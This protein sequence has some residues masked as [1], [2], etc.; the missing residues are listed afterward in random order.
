MLLAKIALLDPNERRT[1]PR[2]DVGMPSTVRGVDAAAVDVVVDDMSASGLAF[3]SDV[4]WAVGARLT[5]G[6]AGGGRATGTIVRNSGSLYG[7]AFDRFLTPDQLATAFSS[8]TS[9][10]R[11][12]SISPALAAVPEAAPTWP[13]GTRVALVVSLAL[14]LW[15]A[16]GTAVFVT[17]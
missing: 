2:S 10:G 5:V 6:L 9:Q 11:D 1:D 4:A 14:L 7:C 15:T 8:R 17:A 3:T 12:L 16:I 13:I